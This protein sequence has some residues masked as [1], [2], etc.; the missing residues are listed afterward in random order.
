MIGISAAAAGAH[1]IMATRKPAMAVVDSGIAEGKCLFIA[2]PTLSE[3]W[4]FLTDNI[5]GMLS[6]RARLRMSWSDAGFLDRD[7]FS[8]IARQSNSHEI[9]Y[10]A[11]LQ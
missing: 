8:Q 10:C 9:T 7:G 4:P 1:K 3:A 6:R 11:L 5:D 2:S